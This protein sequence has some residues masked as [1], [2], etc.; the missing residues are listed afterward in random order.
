[1]KL[2]YT[3]LPVCTII[4]YGVRLGK[5]LLSGMTLDYRHYFIVRNYF[6]LPIFQTTFLSALLSVQF[7][8]QADMKQ[9]NHHWWIRN[10]IKHWRNRPVVESTFVCKP[11]DS[12]SYFVSPRRLQTSLSH[13]CLSP[14]S[15]QQRWTRSYTT[16]R[17][18]IDGTSLLYALGAKGFYFTLWTPTWQTIQNE[19]KIWSMETSIVTVDV[20]DLSPYLLFPRASWK[21][22][23][24]IA[25]VR[26]D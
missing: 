8:V 20:H 11:H 18:S 17:F 15:L 9:D 1:M 22:D 25:N 6:E 23:G 21:W 14:L 4:R 13:R 19:D 7:R 10:E 3:T 26:D 24:S 5:W 2:N 16:W 12:I